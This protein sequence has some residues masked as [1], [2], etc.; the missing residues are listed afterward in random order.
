MKGLTRP[1]VD[2]VKPKGWIKYSL[3][4]D[5]R[6]SVGLFHHV[7]VDMGDLH[8]VLLAL[9]LSI[10]DVAILIMVHQVSLMMSY[11]TMVTISRS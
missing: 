4:I 2:K 6:N 3:Q 9:N 7:F 1:G 8:L 10:L 11:L 5:L